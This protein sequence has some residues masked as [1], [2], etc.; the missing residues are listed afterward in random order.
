MYTLRIVG[1][2]N[3]TRYPTVFQEH[4][5]VTNICGTQPIFS[6]DYR[7]SE[8]IILDFCDTCL[9]WGVE[10]KGVGDSRCFEVIGQ[11]KLPVHAGDNFTMATYK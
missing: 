8:L 7:L 2:R 6:T 4:G 11:F 9:D 3:R 5:E 10:E 1:T